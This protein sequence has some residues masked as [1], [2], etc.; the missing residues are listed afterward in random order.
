MRLAGTSEMVDVAMDETDEVLR[1]LLEEVAVTCSLL[2]Q[3]QRL[4]EEVIHLSLSYF[5]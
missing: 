3:S 1:T 5:D 2:E 4:F